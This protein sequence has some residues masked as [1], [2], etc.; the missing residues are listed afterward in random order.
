MLWLA[1][2]RAYLWEIVDIL[3]GARVLRVLDPPSLAS[4]LAPSGA[5]TLLDRF[6]LA[7]SFQF[8]LAD[9]PI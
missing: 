6:Y 1:N 9:T 4:D 5:Y 2:Y 8:L 3:F 7:V